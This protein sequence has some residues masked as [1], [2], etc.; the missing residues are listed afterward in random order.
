MGGPK[1][2]KLEESKTVFTKFEGQEVDENMSIHDKRALVITSSLMQM[3]NI[4]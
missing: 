3:N 4:K 1:K 2:E